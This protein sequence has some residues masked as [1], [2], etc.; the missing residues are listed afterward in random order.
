M[1]RR[2]VQA[3][4]ST[5]Q[6]AKITGATLRELQIWDERGVLRP[7]RRR[8][9]RGGHG[10]DGMSRGYTERDIR[11]LFVMK[12]LRELHFHPRRIF[13]ADISEASLAMR[14][15]LFDERCNL[16]AASDD[17]SK[18]LAIGAA[19]VGPVVLVEMPF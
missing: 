3:D 9:P 7:S 18:V 19:A 1:E 14:W 2:I 4:Y 8:V 17:Q 6:A 10:G 11:L 13:L 12:R 16:I 15:L 5:A